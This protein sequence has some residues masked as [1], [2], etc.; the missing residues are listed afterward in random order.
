MSRESSAGGTIVGLSDAEA[1]LRLRAEGFNDLP[2]PEQR[3]ILRIVGG[4]LREPMFALLLG[5]GTIYLVLGDLTEALVLLLFATISV[6]IT[7]VQEARSERVLE[8]LREMTSPRA[9]VIRDSVRRRVPGRE[10]VRGDAVV[11]LEGD[12]IPADAVLAAANNLLVDESLLTG[13]ALPVRKSARNGD[14]REPMARPGGED[15]P[16][17]F[18]GT[19]W[20]GEMGW[21][22]CRRPARAARSGGSVKH[23]KESPQSR[24]DCSN[25]PV[26]WFATSPQSASQAA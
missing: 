22:S 7:V 9:L 1:Q 8:A 12:R 18:S 17:V 19:L 25:R 2:R 21:Q 16:F 23:S 14:E 15:Q 20:S 26:G 13:E 10:I 3:T 24:R 11:L 5:A 4:V 6:S